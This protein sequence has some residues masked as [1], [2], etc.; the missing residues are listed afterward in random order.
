M[1]FWRCDSSCLR[2]LVSSVALWRVCGGATGI[3]HHRHKMA[4][5]FVGHYVARSN[6]RFP[7]G[8]AAQRSTARTATRETEQERTQ[9]TTCHKHMQPHLQ[10]RAKLKAPKRV[11]C[12]MW[13]QHILQAVAAQHVSRD[14]ISLCT[15]ELWRS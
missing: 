10:H 11:R 5:K 15:S 8:H 6:W 4:E 13:M 7:H 9:D 2:N 14:S 12:N 1:F 3:P